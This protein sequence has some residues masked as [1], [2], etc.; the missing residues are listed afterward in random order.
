MD[1]NQIL[2]GLAHSA[3]VKAGCKGRASLSYDK[4]DK[5][6]FASIETN[7]AQTQGKA[8]RCAKLLRESYK[9][10]FPHG[11]LRNGFRFMLCIIDASHHLYRSETLVV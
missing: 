6:L 8:D 7:D 10:N 11:L 1:V 2:R 9:R 3:I 5:T 4:H